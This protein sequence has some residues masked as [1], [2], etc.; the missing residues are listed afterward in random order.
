MEELEGTK[1][2]RVLLEQKIGKVY[3]HNLKNFIT[4]ACKLFE[5]NGR[6]AEREKIL[7]KIRRLKLWSKGTAEGTRADILNSLTKEG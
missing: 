6:K 5:A 1:A 7:N 2:Y 3:T 4:Q